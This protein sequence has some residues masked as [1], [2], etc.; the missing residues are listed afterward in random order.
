M[1]KLNKKI[2]F[3]CM[4]LPMLVMICHDMLPHHSHLENSRQ[5]NTLSLLCSGHSLS[6][7]NLNCLADNKQ[8]D[9]C[10]TN[11]SRITP[12]NIYIFFVLPIIYKYISHSCISKTLYYFA[13]PPKIKLRR[14]LIPIKRGPPYL[15]A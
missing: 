1:Y 2:L 9:C 6:Y 4:L 8:H 7:C 15:L 3:W 10:S 14:Y 13:S 5:E 11:H 12:K